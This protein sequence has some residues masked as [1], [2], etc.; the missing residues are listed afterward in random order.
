MSQI[1]TSGPFTFMVKAQ[2]DATR[3]KFAGTVPEYDRGLAGASMNGQS[4]TFT[5]SGVTYHREE[6]ASL[7][8][9]A[10]CQL[11]ITEFGCPTGNRTVAYLGARPA[12]GNGTGPL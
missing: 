6:F 10:Y 5:H 11:G 7:L 2:L 8:Q 1:V 4:F 12:W 3:I 9:D